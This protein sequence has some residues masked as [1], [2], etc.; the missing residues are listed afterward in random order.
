MAERETRPPERPGFNTAERAGRRSLL[1]QVFLDVLQHFFGMF[2]HVHLGINLSNIPLLINDERY[3][4]GE[5][6]WRQDSVRLGRLL[7]GVG[8]EGEIQFLFI[9]ELLLIGE[10]VGADAD[11]NGVE[12]SKLLSEVAVTAGVFRSAAGQGLGEE[13]EDHVLLALEVLQM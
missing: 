10:F 5:A 9:G 13:V 11:D 4:L 12:L 6:A 1:G 2:G 8:E 3:S 7:V